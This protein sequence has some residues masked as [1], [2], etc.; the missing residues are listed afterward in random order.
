MHELHIIFH[1]ANIHRNDILA[2]VGGA[3]GLS[4]FLESVLLKVKVKWSDFA[5]TKTYKKFA[6]TLLHI[7]AFITTIV[8]WY[9]ANLKNYDILPVY[10][11]L[12]IFAQTWHRYAV[13]G[14]FAGVVEPFLAFLSSKKAVTA[15]PATVAPAEP[16]AAPSDQFIG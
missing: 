2:L 10:G 13:S 15:K 16:V 5:K 4:V 11:S 9:L 6:Y 1:W 14:F 8:T 3:A 12:V 7:S